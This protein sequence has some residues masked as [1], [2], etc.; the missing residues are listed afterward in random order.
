MPSI[1]TS[2][3]LVHLKSADDGYI[4]KCV[5]I[6]MEFQYKIRVE[7]NADFLNRRNLRNLNFNVN[8]SSGPHVARHWNSHLSMT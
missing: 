3:T 7:I 5:H 8:I 4:I 2:N 1:I 6:F